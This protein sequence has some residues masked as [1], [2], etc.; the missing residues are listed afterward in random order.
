MEPNVIENKVVTESDGIIV[1]KNEKAKSV[2]LD[3]VV[4]QKLKRK[5]RRGKHKPKNSNWKFQP[6]YNNGTGGGGNG[7]GGHGP[8]QRQRSKLIR[9]NSLAPYNTNRFLM[10]EHMVEVPLLGNAGRTRDSSFSVDS[11]DNYF[12]SLPEDEEDFLSKEFSNVYEKARVERL[13]NLS[14]QELIQE[15]L[16][17]EDRFT[18]DQGTQ[19][20]INIQRITTE[21]MSR[22]R[23]LEQKN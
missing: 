7:G 12:Y 19:S 23:A 4:Q 22:I 2:V 14:K 11:E 9:S 10:E 16:Q 17:M 8:N 20:Q 21:F 3:D 5:H 18:T 1:N 6:K 13:E 15:C